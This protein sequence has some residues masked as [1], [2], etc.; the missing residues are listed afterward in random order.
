MAWF[1]HDYLTISNGVISKTLP[2]YSTSNSW[3]D[4][5]YILFKQDINSYQSRWHIYDYA[6]EGV[7]SVSTTTFYKY[8]PVDPLNFSY[9][10]S[11]TVSEASA[12]AQGDPHIKPLFGKDYTI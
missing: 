3:Y 5:D 9:T 12:G 11:W 4:G 7:I 1:E 2:W 10:N 8:S 6:Q